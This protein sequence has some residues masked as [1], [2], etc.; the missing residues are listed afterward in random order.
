MALMAELDDWEAACALLGDL[1]YEKQYVAIRALLH[2]QNEAD[3]ELKKEMDEID[4]FAR[5]AT[6]SA[7]E[8]A[9]EDWGVAFYDSI[10]QGAAHS[11]AAVG[12]LAPFVESLFVQAFAGIRDKPHLGG[13]L[14]SGHARWAMDAEVRWD[15][16]FGCNTKAIVVG[17]TELAEFTGLAPHLPADLRLTLDALFAYRNKMF[18]NGFE[19]PL[20]ERTK[21]AKRVADGAWPAD[22]FRSA[23]TNGEP[24]V[25]YLTDAY[26]THCLTVIEAVLRGFGAFVRERVN[27]GVDPS[28]SPWA[29]TDGW[30][31]QS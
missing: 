3:T 15:P 27:D 23:T 16:H 4:A 6:G 26:I 30:E 9:V 22:W 20:A 7:N 11:M 19:W 1:D 31:D 24:W 8:R 14:V 13:A 25:F 28:A 12:M 5:R 10:F 29:L 17:I 21:F 18:H 2:R